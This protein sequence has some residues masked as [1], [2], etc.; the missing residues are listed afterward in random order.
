MDVQD[1]PAVQELMRI[2]FR[3]DAS[4]QIGTGH[5]MR[6]LTLADALRERGA[7]CSFICRQHPGNLV[8]LIKQ[9]GHAVHTLPADDHRYPTTLAQPAHAAWLGAD[10]ATDAEQTRQALGQENVD[11][12][13]VDHYALDRQWETALRPYARKI[14]VIDDLADRPHDGDLLL[15]QNLGRTKE[16]YAG[17]LKLGTR[18][19]I[20]PQYALLRPEFAQWRE[21]SLARR[22]QPQLKNLLITMGGVDNGNATGQVVDALKTCELPDDLNIT[23]VMG[24]HAPWLT[25]VQ[26]LAISMPWPVKVLAGVSNMAQL[27]A[28]SDLAIGAAGGTAWERCTLG[29]P[30]LLLVLAENQK[31]GALALQKAGA[32]LMVQDIDELHDLLAPLTGIAGKPVALLQLSNAAASLTDGKGVMHVVQKMLGSYV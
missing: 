1:Y 19:L 8:D 24:P 30:T 12:L 25:Q 31:S 18:T 4:I 10:W 3:T 5:V 15:D 7:Q 11:W 6:C 22:T 32:A 29:L 23:I 2:A 9:R 26:A 13:V 28:D 20:G 21:Y 14:M 16:D 17:L 27:M